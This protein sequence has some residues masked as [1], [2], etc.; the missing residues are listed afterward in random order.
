MRNKRDYNQ[1]WSEYFK[2][3]EKSPSG[4]MRVKNRVGKGIKE[5]AVGTQAY[6]E[7]GAAHSWRLG[8]Q[9]NLYY[10]HRIIWVMTYGIITAELVIDHLDGNPFNNQID[11][12]SL[13]TP[14]DNARNMKQSCVNKTGFTGVSLTCKGSCTYYAARWSEA[15]KEKVE[16][17]KYFSVAKLGEEKAKEM[18]ISY[19]EEQILRLIAEGAD[20][21]DRHG[22]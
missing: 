9:G 14:A 22:T 10:I 13:K 20:Y 2:V 8:F 15:G 5:Y 17:V 7:K 19:R 21:T 12:L 16:G 3:D 6:S 11:N 4:L 1:D 18:A